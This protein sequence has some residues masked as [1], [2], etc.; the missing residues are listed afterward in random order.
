MFF[1]VSF[2]VAS[3]F[4]DGRPGCFLQLRAG[5]VFHHH[6]QPQKQFSGISPELPNPSY[7]SVHTPTSFL[8]F[9]IAV[10]S[11]ARVGKPT[12]RDELTGSATGSGR[13]YV[14]PAGRISRLGLRNLSDTLTGWAKTRAMKTESL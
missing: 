1:P 8:S 2:S 6:P 7:F 14:Y 13:Y 11:V 3:F 9:Q 12:R 10:L 4:F 5:L